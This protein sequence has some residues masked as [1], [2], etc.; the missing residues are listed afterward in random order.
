MTGRPSSSICATS[1]TWF[2][3]STLRK[4]AISCSEKP[5]FGAKN[6]RPKRLRAGSS[7]RREHPAL[8][9]GRSARISIGPTV[10]KLLDDRIIGGFRH[11]ILSGLSN[12]RAALPASVRFE[13]E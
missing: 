8:S 10:A 11:E 6:R 9:L 7:D 12:R 13:R 5:F 2:P 3:K 1:A 4:K